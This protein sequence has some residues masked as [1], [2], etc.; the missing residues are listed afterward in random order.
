[1]NGLST[2][3]GSLGDWLGQP[4]NP[5]MSAKDWFLFGGLIIVI[6]SAWLMILRDLKGAIE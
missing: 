6:V 5:Q 4:F 3:F 2:T 1:M